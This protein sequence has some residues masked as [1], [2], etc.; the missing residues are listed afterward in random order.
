VPQDYD[1]VKPEFNRKGVAEDLEV[2]IEHGP[3]LDNIPGTGDCVEVSARQCT[4]IDY[5]LNGSF[6]LSGPGGGADVF[7]D[8]IESVVVL[9]DPASPHYGVYSA[10]LHCVGGAPPPSAVHQIVTVVPG[11]VLTLSFWTRNDGVYQ[12]RYRVRDETHATDIIAFT[13][14]PLGIPWVKLTHTFTIPAGCVSI[15]V[16]LSMVTIFGVDGDVWYDDVTLTGECDTNRGYEMC[17]DRCYMALNGSSSYVDSGSDATLDDLPPTGFTAEAMVKFGI[18]DAG[19]VLFGKTDSAGGGLI[20][21]TVG[22]YLEMSPTVIVGI[23]V[24]DDGFGMPDYWITNAIIPSIS[25]GEWHHIAM[26]YS[27]V[28]FFIHLWLDGTEVLSA[29]TQPLVMVYHSDAAQNLIL[30]RGDAGAGY[31]SGNVM[32]IRVSSSNLY[33]VAFTPPEACD[34]IVV[35][36]NTVLLYN[37]R[38]CSDIVIDNAQGDLDKDGTPHNINMEDLDCECTCEDATLGVYIANKHNRAQLT[39][40]FVFDAAPAGYSFNL[41]DLG[42]PYALLP[43]VPAI[44]DI[45]YIG[46]D[47]NHPNYGPFCSLAYDIGTAASGVTWTYEYW[48]GAAWVALTVWDNTRTAQPLD[49]TGINSVHWAQP[50][51][52]ATRVVNGVVALWVRI[53]VTGVAA[54]VAPTQQNRHIYTVIWPY[55]DI[56]ALDAPGDLPAQF[57]M[58]LYNVVQSVLGTYPVRYLLGARAINRGADFSAYLPCSD[59]QLPDGITSVGVF[60]NAVEDVTGRVARYVTAGA[61]AE[62]INPVFRFEL[63]SAIALQYNG[64]FRMYLV[65][66]ADIANRFLVRGVVRATTGGGT[67]I[68][69]RTQTQTVLSLV[70]GYFIDLGEVDIQSELLSNAPFQLAIEAGANAGAGVN[71]I[72][73]LAMILLPIDEWCG[74]FVASVSG[75]YH[76]PGGVPLSFDS[77]LALKD[78][79]ISELGARPT[80]YNRFISIASKWTMDMRNDQRVWIFNTS[81][82]AGVEI[83]PFIQVDKLLSFEAV[84]RYMSMRGTE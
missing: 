45:L 32:N 78:P 7:A 21:A 5:I 60:G 82:S 12:G 52:W 55:V 79:I 36:S 29:R 30:G 72:Q 11:T 23:M 40:I 8:W 66:D 58:A 67:Q 22:W 10:C 84:K 77:V 35:L 75:S 15:G 73:F 28:D 16:Y 6:E 1:I 26:T 69:Q 54:P 39:H 62:A 50:T 33:T 42:L 49:K 46:I 9:A 25:D 81:I 51:A 18:T 38:G 37:S 71:T 56:E 65:V 48:N 43:A 3:W 4:E 76:W 61:G 63:S 19:G 17:I 64:R 47:V 31:F 83:S 68:L 27:A 14:T 44:G 74:D 13:N 59:V 24:G 53:R 57:A 80:V 34:D 20:D 41:L 2:S 70:D